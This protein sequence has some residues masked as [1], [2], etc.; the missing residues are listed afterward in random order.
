M[1]FTYDSTYHAKK[2]GRIYFKAPFIEVVERSHYADHSGMSLLI[3]F[4]ASDGQMFSADVAYKDLSAGV[5]KALAKAIDMGLSLPHGDGAKAAQAALKHYLQEYIPAKTMTKLPSI[6]YTHSQSGWVYARP[7]EVIGD[8]EKTFA[9]SCP[10]IDYADRIS[11]RGT[12]ES[13]QRSVIS[14]FKTHPQIVF[15]CSVA[16]AGYL[17][18]FTGVGNSIIHFYH[19]RQ[20]IGKTSTL[21]AAASVLGKVGQSS[22]DM[23]FMSSWNTTENAPEEVFTEHNDMTALL[24]ELVLLGKDENTVRPLVRKIAHVLDSGRA[25]RRMGAWASKNNA[26]WNCFALSTGNFSFGPTRDEEPEK[27]V[28]AA[29]VRF[30]DI[31]FLFNE[32]DL[33]AEYE[34]PSLKQVLPEQ[35]GILRKACQASYGVAGKAFITH[36]VS[37]LNSK[38]ETHLSGIIR[39]YMGEFYNFIRIDLSNEAKERTAKKFALAYA[40]AKIAKDAGIWGKYINIE[41]IRK[42]I[43]A[44]YVAYEHT[45]G[46]FDPDMAV[47]AA[48]A[49][50]LQNR[51]KFVRLTAET[52]PRSEADFAEHKS[53]YGF[54]YKHRQDGKK[55]YLVKIPTF[56]KRLCKGFFWKQMIDALDEAGYLERGNEKRPSKK[57]SWRTDSAA[58]R[59]SFYWIDASILKN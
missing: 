3:K 46:A 34:L 55:Y 57:V 40:A 51:S 49:F 29:E 20:G 48:K 38:A 41:R 58:A 19:N 33:L 53:A 5:P 10:G 35:C 21:T 22:Q 56:R 25:R 17:L 8:E 27:R 37:I 13:W 52:Q 30:I 39:E 6:G 36:V 44:C 45:H 43:A 54:V 18:R 9:L 1:T 15:A 32:R 28:S 7:E 16:F 42:S 24:D 2:G 12:L 31:P 14:P 4:K 50:I 23:A 11:V 59:K 26:S 47:A